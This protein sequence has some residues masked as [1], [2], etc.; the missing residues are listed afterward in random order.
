VFPSAEVAADGSSVIAMRPGTGRLV[1]VGIVTAQ[2]LH[3]IGPPAAAGR[4]R[5]LDTVAQVDAA[6]PVRLRWVGSRGTRTRS[7]ASE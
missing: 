1:S 6:S 3:E 2:L 7:G 5:A 4:H